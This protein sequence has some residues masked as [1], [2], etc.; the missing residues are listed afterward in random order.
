MQTPMPMVVDPVSGTCAKA[1]KPRA[2]SSTLSSPMARPQHHPY[3]FQ[4]LLDVPRRLFH[5]PPAQVKVGRV[6]SMS[7]TP[8]FEV[9][10][11]DVLDGQHL[12]PL[13]RKD[14]EEY[15][16][17]V[18]RSPENLYFTQWLR[19]YSRIHDA[20][21][22]SSTSYSPQL[23]LSWSRAK[24]TFFTP[25]AHLRLNL[26][27]SLLA[28]IVLPDD[29]SSARVQYDYTG[30]TH[31]SYPPPPALGKIH[32][33]VEDMLRESLT[34]F[35]SNSCG[36][37]GRARGLFGIALGVITMVTGLAPVLLSVLA[38]RPRALRA[39]AIPVFWLGAWITIMSLHGV[40]IVIFLFGDARQ[41]YPYELARPKITHPISRPGNGPTVSGAQDD[42]IS[43][44]SR[45]ASDARLYVDLERGNGGSTSTLGH[46]PVPGSL[47]AASTVPGLDR[48][49]ENCEL[50]VMSPASTSLRQDPGPNSTQGSPANWSF[51]FDAL[52]GDSPTA[53]CYDTKSEKPKSLGEG[54]PMFCPLT[55]VLNPVISRTQ[56]EVVVRSAALAV[57]VAAVLGAICLAVPAC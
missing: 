11:C 29:A 56:W 2:V 54:I 40:C 25:Q 28:G 3:A 12:P 45:F 1:L 57:V 7:L 22:Q 44:K 39:A 13:S 50:A 51:D 19:D 8:L 47:S 26:P 34:R 35:V 23:A 38:E 6:R 10:L 55:R 5:P 24:E 14:F 33:E 4:A 27:A 32:R 9:K 18:E 16:L 43:E 15:L 49:A 21:A 41:L 17:F 30:P 37:S 52:P 48:D 42:V 36:N 46:K 53:L 20:W 31:P